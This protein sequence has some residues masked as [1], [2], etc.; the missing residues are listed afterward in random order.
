MCGVAAPYKRQLAP[1]ASASH[2]GSAFVL[3]RMVANMAEKIQPA[4]AEEFCVQRTPPEGIAGVR[5]GELNI[6]VRNRYQSLSNVRRRESPTDR[7]T[8][9][10]VALALDITAMMAMVP[11]RQLTARRGGCRY[12]TA[13]CH[14]P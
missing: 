7:D 14:S 12:M 9:P 10:S 6:Q 1:M 5:G 13:Q 2:V 3:R 4:K 8:M 11:S